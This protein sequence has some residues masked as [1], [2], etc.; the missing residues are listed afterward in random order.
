MT[1]SD[2]IANV[3]L[4]ISIIALLVT[5]AQ[6]LSQVF[7][8]A[9]GHRRC[10][11][12]VIGGWAKLTKRKWRWTSFRFETYFTTPHI[13]IRTY[14]YQRTEYVLKQTA[15]AATF[16]FESLDD[17]DYESPSKNEL[18][19][20][21]AFLYVLQKSLKSDERI[22]YLHRVAYCVPDHAKKAPTTDASLPVT[23]RIIRSWDF[24]PPEVVRPFAST[25]ASDIAIIALRMGMSWK[26]FKPEEGT[27]EAE[28]NGQAMSSTLVRALG[29]LLRYTYTPQHLDG[30]HSPT[31]KS[32]LENPMRYTDARGLLV[33]T[34]QA[35]KMWFGILRGNTE[36]LGDFG[37]FDFP[38]GEQQSIYEVVMKMDPSGGAKRAL[39]SAAP[40]LWGF[41]D[42]I[43]MLAP[44]LR[45][46]GTLIRTVPAVTYDVVG[47]TCYRAAYRAFRTRLESRAEQTGDSR[48]AIMKV[49]TTWDDLEKE[50]PDWNQEEKP[51][52]DR[53]RLIGCLDSI[54]LSYAMTTGYFK[55]IKETSNR[56]LYFPLVKAHLIRAASVRN[57]IFEGLKSKNL[58]EKLLAL[59][60]MHVYWDDMEYYKEAMSEFGWESVEE[61][62]IVEDSWIMLMF[63]AFLW[64][65]AH[66]FDIRQKPLPSRYYGSQLPVYIG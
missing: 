55:K 29:I 1:N 39:E 18:A 33:E 65:A 35:D 48:P 13:V 37:G 23:Y 38:I 60:T 5:T 27:M 66:V 19:C 47:L 44:W 25:T 30:I 10:Q 6:L 7:A 8:T 20:W 40:S 16:S 15:R 53:N 50:F 62:D 45:Q 41:N 43:P 12:S 22:F 52:E 61:R 21:I 56:D 3:A 11:P 59:R 31:F 51:Y 4:V 63:R 2:S 58:P 46:D 28:G 36:L 32:Y 34:T 9:E 42:I 57:K 14:W 26:I 17:L 49:L 24:M 64:S 54:Q